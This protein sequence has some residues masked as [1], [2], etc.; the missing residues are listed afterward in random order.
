MPLNQ[1]VVA[2]LINDKL[3]AES[4]IST[5]PI[6]CQHVWQI[7]W[8]P[9]PRCCYRKGEMLSKSY[10]D[11]VSVAMVRRVLRPPVSEAPDIFALLMSNSKKAEHNKTQTM[12]ALRSETKSS[13]AKHS[14]QALTSPHSHTHTLPHPLLPHPH[15]HTIINPIIWRLRLYRVLVGKCVCV[16]VRERVY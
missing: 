16:C 9:S 11:A 4:Q 13:W 8:W 6:R 10:M 2:S 1:W 5:E 14:R 12:Y 15:T 7:L 3:A